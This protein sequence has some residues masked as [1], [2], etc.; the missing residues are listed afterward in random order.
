MRANPVHQ[1]DATFGVTERHQILSH[2]SHA[3]RRTVRL[4]QFLGER[5]RLP[6]AAEIFA[7]RRFRIRLRQDVILFRCQH[8]LPLR[9]IVSRKTAGN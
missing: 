3:Q 9:F 1:T 7:H 8:L 6:E 4:G 5:D 2:D